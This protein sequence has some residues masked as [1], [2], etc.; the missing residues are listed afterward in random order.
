MAGHYWFGGGISVQKQ[1]S[2]IKANIVASAAVLVVIIS[3]TDY[4]TGYRSVG[5]SRCGFRTKK[6]GQNFKESI[7][8]MQLSVIGTSEDDRGNRAGTSARRFGGGALAFLT[9]FSFFGTFFF[10]TLSLG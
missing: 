3:D 1:I 6:T 10:G 9:A 7:C 4:H 5:E 2:D 8:H